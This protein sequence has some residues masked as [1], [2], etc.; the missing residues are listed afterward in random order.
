MSVIVQGYGRFGNQFIRNIAINFLTSKFDL[1]CIYQSNEQMKE[2]GIELYSG[3]KYNNHHQNVDITDNNFITVLNEDTL[4]YNIITNIYNYYQTKEISNMIYQ[5][6]HRDDIKNNI[7]EKNPF[8]ERYNNNNDVHIHIRLGDVI[9]FNPGV[10]YFICA[11]SKI[12]SYDN[13]YIST[14]SPEHYIIQELLEK[15]LSAKLLNYNEVQTFQFA[16]TCKYQILSHG[17]FSTIIGYLAFYSTIYYSEYNPS[18][19]W[20]GD[21]FSIDGWNKIPLESYL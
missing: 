15:Y 17:S 21:T 19:V 4:N 9:S 3:N 14:D 13:I 11:L 7:I 18:L 5:Y 20:Y 10:N 8:K 1:A 2:L 16:S 12:K 6:L